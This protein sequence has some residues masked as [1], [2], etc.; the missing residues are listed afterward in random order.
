MRGQMYE[1][2]ENIDKNPPQ[3]YMP[4]TAKHTRTNAR[5]NLSAA[6]EFRSVLVRADLDFDFETNER[7]INFVLDFPFFLLFFFY[8][9]SFVLSSTEQ[10]DLFVL[11][12]VLS[13]I[14]SATHSLSYLTKQIFRFFCFKYIFFV[15]H[16]HH[17]SPFPFRYCCCSSLVLLQLSFRLSRVILNLDSGQFAHFFLVRFGSTLL[18]MMIVMI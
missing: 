5:R 7:I 13:S 11:R 16:P 8:F 9:S 4:S 15:A 3:K 2:N 12:F 6:F 10:I 14:Y 18:M 1:Q 17:P